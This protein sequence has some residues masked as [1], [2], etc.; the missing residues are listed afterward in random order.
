MEKRRYPCSCD[1]HPIVLL[2]S[3]LVRS[4]SRPH[5]SQ[6]ASHTHTRWRKSTHI[7]HTH[8][9]LTSTAGIL[10]RSDGIIF[11]SSTN[12][13]DIPGFN[14]AGLYLSEALP[15]QDCTAKKMADVIKRVWASVW[16]YRGYVERELFGIVQEEVKVA[17]LVQPWFS[18]KVQRCN[19]CIHLKL[20]WRYC[21]C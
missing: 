7:L 20:K 3:I 19:K 21:W 8:F 6:N 17:I 5:S 15:S 12:V 4:M 13:E 1:P 10:K 18:K 14:G 16:N 11:R 2:L 9:T